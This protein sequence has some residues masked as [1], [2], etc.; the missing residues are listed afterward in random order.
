ML[1]LTIVALMAAAVAAAPV[2][3]EAP[4]QWTGVPVREKYP[5]KT[6]AG[7]PAEEFPNAHYKSP[8]IGQVPLSIFSVEFQR[9]NGSDPV[10]WGARRQTFYLG[11]ENQNAD[12]W[13]PIY[14][15]RKMKNP[16]K[17][18]LYLRGDE[19]FLFGRRHD[20]L[21]QVYVDRAC[22]FNHQFLPTPAPP[23]GILPS[24]R[25]PP[26]SFF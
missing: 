26:C 3:D 21:Q 15:Y 24:F 4:P 17:A 10:P 9:P 20:A 2:A 11:L 19:L 22:T 12:C 8:G 18:L 13:H 6:N 14:K 5:E 16:H 1:I 23:S 7:P 25:F